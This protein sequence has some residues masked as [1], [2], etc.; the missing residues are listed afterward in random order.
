MVD[1]D[2]VL[3]RN[4]HI[5]QESLV[6]LFG[7][8]IGDDSFVGPFVEITRGVTVGKRC[9]IE[10]HAF[11]CYSV[12]VRDNVFIGHGVTFTND[13]YPRVNRRVRYIQTT[14][15]DYASIG[16]NATI[17]CGVTLGRYCV[18]G[19]GAVVTKD[20]PDYAISAGNPAKVIRQ[21]ANEREMLAYMTSRQ[22]LTDRG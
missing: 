8:S 21:F 10:S 14:V 13:L 17:V 12:T 11:L 6:N 18:V 2:V 16:S 4:V 15:G 20:V 1:K 19:A 3:G 22:E 9:K 7:C 5:F